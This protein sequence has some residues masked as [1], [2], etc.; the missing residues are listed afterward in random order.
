MVRSECGLPPF[1]EVSAIETNPLGG[2][3][4]FTTRI[5]HYQN[6]LMTC[7]GIRDALALGPRLNILFY[8][9]VYPT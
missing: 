3:A 5:V 8:C 7:V 9:Q 2:S 4:E 6:L 1:M